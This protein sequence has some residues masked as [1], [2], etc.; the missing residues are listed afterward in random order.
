MYSLLFFRLLLEEQS[1][2]WGIKEIN[3][4]IK[5][6]GDRDL[7]KTKD[8]GHDRTNKQQTFQALNMWPNPLAVV[9]TYVYAL[10]SPSFLHL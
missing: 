4:L 2:P 10:N 6:P 3:G 1:L 8:L 7:K 5:S 9:P